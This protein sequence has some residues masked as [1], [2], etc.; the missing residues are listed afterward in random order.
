M[1]A[2]R[3]K[4]LAANSDA[5]A[6]SRRAM[7]P[8]DPVLT[9]SAPRDARQVTA[10]FPFGLVKDLR[11]DDRLERWTLRFLVPVDVADGTYEARVVIVKRDGTLELATASYLIDSCAPDFDVELVGSRIRIRVNEPARKVTVA[12]AVDP[13]R[14]RVLE[15][16]GR[17]FEGE[18]PASGRLR[19]V[20][21]DLA[22]NEGVREVDAP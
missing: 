20:V 5:A 11:W 2:D 14:R 4:V 10:Y 6:L 16:D 7:P 8:G 21:A 12:S 17:V 3:A 15:G 19:V 9:V 18:V 1:R 22:R 13:R